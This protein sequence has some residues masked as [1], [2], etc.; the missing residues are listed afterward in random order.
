MVAQKKL[1][2]PEELWKEVERLLP[3]GGVVGISGFGGSGKTTLSNAIG[4]DA[5]GV[6]H[7]HVDDYL[8]WPRVQK[9]CA[10]WEGIDFDSII[11][12][13]IKPFRAGT[14][15]VKYLVIEGIR[16]FTDDLIK[17]FD[18][19]IWVDTPIDV[20]EKNGRGR[21]GADQDLWDTVWRKSD[22]DFFNKH[23]PKQ[24]ADIL[25]SWMK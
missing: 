16:I 19:K 1:R 21:D 18:V 17:N 4:R 8:D 14:K 11:S 24:Y 5:Q 10:D 12:A 2:S 13:H 23:N 22:E 9:Y 25:Y 6:Q 20:A 3:D 7:V 15:P